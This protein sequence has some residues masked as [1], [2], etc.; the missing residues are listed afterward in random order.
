[1]RFIT[2][3][4]VALAAGLALTGCSEQAAEVVTE[5]SEQPSTQAPAE[6]TQEPEADSGTA[7]IGDTVAIGDWEVTVTE[8]EPNANERVAAANEFNEAPTGQYVL[9]QYD[10]TYNGDERSDD[11]LFSLMWAF[12]GSDGTVYEP[13]FAVDESDVDPW[14]TEARQGGSVTDQ[15]TFDV[16]AEAIEGGLVEVSDLF[17]TEYAEFPVSTGPSA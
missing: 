17:G 2:T 13:A 16:P 8:V 10:A 6:P 1:M 12:L 9:V 7:S 15:V 11:V 4:A 3:T 5:A 14:P